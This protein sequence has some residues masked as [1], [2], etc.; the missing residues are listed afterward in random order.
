MDTAVLDP[1]AARAR[2]TTSGLRTGMIGYMLAHE[3]FTVP[4]LVEIGAAAEKAGFDFLA[5]SDHFQPWQANE[6]HS[7]AAWVTMAA[8]GARA[9]SAWLGT[10][11]TCPILRYSPAVVAEAF[12]SLSLLYPG[13]IF[14]GVGSGEALNE[15]AATGQWPD[16][17]ERWE[18]LIEAIGIIRCLWT[19]QH[20]SHSG[21][22]Y[23]VDAR[24]YDAPPEPIPILTAANGKKAMRLAGEHGDGLITDPAT[25]KEFRGEWEAGAKAAGKDPATMPVI[26]EV[27][28]VVGGKAEAEKSA[29][30]WRFIPKAFE[31]YFGIGDPVEIQ[32][33]AEAEV[34][35]E[36]VCSEWAIGTDPKVH[37]EAVQ[38]LFDS[39]IK[40]INIH[41][42]QME[43]Q[44]AIEFYGKEV[45][46][47]LRKRVARL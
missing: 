35:M 36:K 11:V 38:A 22:Y 8:L 44:R 46:P 16:W 28:V 24:L 7:G 23:R 34:P 31:S 40:L 19:G 12:A 39:G 6:G 1:T 45:L 13:R 4:Q 20:V 27:F 37:I 18:R 15:Q 30:L 41:V 3:Q 5:H 32:R 2:R 9:Q 17:D 10:F 47:V 21:K 25:W 33:R 42:G 29:E 26:A 43:Q 14:L